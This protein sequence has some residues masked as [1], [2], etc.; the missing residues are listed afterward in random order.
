MELAEQ[1]T[2]IEI[3]QE[4]AANQR[5]KARLLEEENE[6]VFEEHEQQKL[7]EEEE[8]KFFDELVAATDRQIT[9]FRNQLED[10]DTGVVHALIENEHAL[11]E[12]R[13]RREELESSAYRLPD[14]RMVFKTED[15]KRVFDQNG[16]ELPHDAMDPESIP[17]S[18]PR[19]EPLKTLVETEQKLLRD[20]QELHR[21]QKKI[22]DAR[23]VVDKGGITGKRLEE[24][25]ADLKREMPEAVK[26]GLSGNVPAQESAGPQVSG[27]AQAARP[28]N[29]A[30]DFSP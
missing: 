15:G 2:L 27:P 22:D 24:L 21:F 20:R 29:G 26:Q 17:D 4:N 7:R 14:G 28:A 25:D 18:R 6:R 13:K 8:K 12:V 11:D 19:W 16:A 9:A 23:D 30:R 10:Y 3:F 1:L 5:R